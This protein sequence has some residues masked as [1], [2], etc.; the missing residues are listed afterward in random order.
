MNEGSVVEISSEVHFNTHSLLGFVAVP[1]LV[2]NLVGKL[3]I[4][5]IMDAD[6]FGMGLIFEDFVK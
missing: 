4:T 2:D 3:I 6:F 5:I 1:I